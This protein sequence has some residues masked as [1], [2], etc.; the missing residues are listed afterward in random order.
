MAHI[1][2]P[3]RNNRQQAIQYILLHELAHVLAI[4]ENFHPFW[5]I[6]PKDIAA[7][8]GY[9]FFL[10]SWTVDRVNNRFASLFDASFSRRRDV[11]YYFGAKLDADRMVETYDH[12]GRTNF[13]TLYAVTSPGDDFAEAFASYVHT[14]LMKKPFAIRIYHRGQLARAY[15]SCWNEA[16][17]ADKRKLLE[18]FLNVAGPSP[19]R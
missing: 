3:K 17:C 4:E 8:D 13:P 18:R 2:T 14:V 1:E 9:P 6:D 10:L 12:L 19:L 15:G 7:T 5:G 11:V 16:R